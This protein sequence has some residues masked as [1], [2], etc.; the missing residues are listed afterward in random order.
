MY[1]KTEKTKKYGKQVSKHFTK[2]LNIKGIIGKKSFHSLRHSFSNYFKMRDLH[3]D[4]FRQVFGH[5]IP[6]LAGNTY[7]ERFSAKICYEKIIKKLNYKFEN[8]IRGE[9]RSRNSTDKME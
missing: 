7:G 9:G 4:V 6:N 1:P 2:L 3:T 5:E 8:E